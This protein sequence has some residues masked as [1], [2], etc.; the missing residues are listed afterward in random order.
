MFLILDVSFAVGRRQVVRQSLSRV[1]WSVVES[2]NE[3]IFI[4]GVEPGD[5]DAP[6]AAA[7]EEGDDDQDELEKD[8]EEKSLLAD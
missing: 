3:G 6:S 4:D 1:L 7:E 8:E 5:V 2:R